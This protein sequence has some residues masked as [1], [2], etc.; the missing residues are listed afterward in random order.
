M[1]IAWHREGSKA[2]L[3]DDSG[4]QSGGGHAHAVRN[5]HIEGLTGDDAGGF[6]YYTAFQ[7]LMEVFKIVP[8]ASDRHFQH[9]KSRLQ[10]WERALRQTNKSLEIAI[11]STGC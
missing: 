10:N 4:L 5:R 2:L 6:C 1:S 8:G 9:M 11:S 7:E 3:L